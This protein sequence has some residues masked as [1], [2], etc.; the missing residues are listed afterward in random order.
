[1]GSDKVITLDFPGNGWLY[2]EAS[3]ASVAEN[4]KPLQISLDQLGIPPPYRVIALSLGLWSPWNGAG[5]IPP[6]LKDWF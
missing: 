1:L 2:A 4:G 3:S 6:N 5:N